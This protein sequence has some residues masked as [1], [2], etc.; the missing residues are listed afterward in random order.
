MLSWPLGRVNRLFLLRFY[1]VSFI[2][3]QTF[4]KGNTLYWNLNTT[5]CIFILNFNFIYIFT[6]QMNII[7]IFKCSF[8]ISLSI[9]HR[10]QER[11]YLDLLNYMLVSF[12]L[13][14]VH[15]W[16]PLYLSTPSNDK[17]VTLMP[18]YR[19]IHLCFHQ[20][21]FIISDSLSYFLRLLIQSYGSKTGGSF[22]TSTVCF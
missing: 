10:C 3:S 14:T 1:L 19:H 16:N 4:C 12:Q 9:N 15:N 11:Y 20:N 13:H 8:F 18:N 5:Y 21:Y 6:R 2:T 22:A 7:S 17:I